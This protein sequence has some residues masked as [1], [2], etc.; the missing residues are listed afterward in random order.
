M[1]PADILHLS[2]S[3]YLP[4]HTA[5]EILSV[6]VSL[7]VFS[8]GWVI[9]DGARGRRALILGLSAAAAGG[10]DFLHTLS[11]PGMPD[12]LTPS[13]T[14]KGIN[15]WLLA[16]L[17]L[18]AGL[19]A[20]CFDRGGRAVPGAR[21][22][23]L[24]LAAILA[25]PAGIVGLIRPE[26]FPDTF[27][28][29]IGLTPF[30]I[31]AEWV[32]ALAY[33]AV[34]SLLLH[35]AVVAHDRNEAKLAA[36]AWLL[37]LT[38]VM[39]T[40]Y[41]AAGDAINLSGHGLKALAY[42]LI[43]D[44][45]FVSGVK[46]PNLALAQE[47]ALLRTLMDSV[48]DLIFFK[49]TESRYLGYNKA[50]VAYCGRPEAEMLGKTDFD[51]APSE[52][53][54]F[55]RAKDREA[56]AAGRP[57][58]NEEWIEYP[59]GRR[60]LLDTVK[61]PIYDA[62]GRLLGLAGISRDITGRKYAEEELRRA[63]ADLEM[64]TGVTAHDLQEPARTIASF[65]QLLQ[66]RYGDR[67]DGE[68]GQYIA[69][70]VDGSRRMRA[71]LAALLEYTQID[72]DKGPFTA[73]DCEAALTEALDGLRDRIVEADAVVRHDPL[74]V[75]TGSPPQLRALFANLIANALKF[76]RPGHPPEVHV[77]A[78]RGD[79]G[80][81]FTVRDNGIGIE[82]AYWDKIFLVFQRLHP[83]DRYEGTGIGLAICRK[84]VE[85]HGGIIAVRSV[86]GEGSI[87]TFTLPIRS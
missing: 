17:A 23:G 51:F 44:S 27:E 9:Q 54:E 59:D 66:L 76:R 42:M 40:L 35:G 63:H 61:A 20:A 58:G 85:R 79:G 53:A 87:F 45:L 55:Y 47:R 52:V 77:S 7:M 71:Q 30:K 43:Y 26:W 67:L 22:V 41:A 60:V 57:S 4:I 38:E 1:L 56:M 19:V 65:L 49:D 84:I 29:G 18:A 2:P 24:A 81:T 78:E 64:V 28:P 32:L 86:P 70:A 83:L 48:P 16:R 39:L 62:Q 80:W 12:L 3:V 33:V 11:Y 46:A 73:V 25:L 34:A 14:E 36:A 50:F 10:L 21:W 69:Y 72:H 15:L 13:S 75:V 5:L 8:L 31:G 74:P 6:A 68:A 37:A 82:P